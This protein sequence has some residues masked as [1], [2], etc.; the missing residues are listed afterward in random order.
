[1][2]QGSSGW[3]DACILVPWALYEVYGDQTILEENYDMMIR[4][5]AFVEKR[6][7]K[8]RIQNLRNPYKKYL[9]DEGFHFGEIGRASCRERV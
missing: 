8:T 6:A 7:Q 3:G 1:M 2:L 4:W 9:V 5:L